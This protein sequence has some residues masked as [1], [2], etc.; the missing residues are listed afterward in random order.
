MARM[1]LWMKQGWRPGLVVIDS[2]ESAGLP[3]DSNNVRPW[4]QQHV[5][6]FLSMGAG[7]LLLDHVPKRREDRPRGGIGSQHKLARIDGAALFLDG[8]PWTKRDD[9]RVT[10]RVHKDRLGD[11][12]AAVKKAVAVVEVTHAEDGLLLYAINPPDADDDTAQDV[13]LPLLEAIASH[14]PQGVR[15][16]KAVRELLKVRGRLIDVALEDLMKTG[17]VVKAKDGRASIF[18]VTA[19]GEQMLT[20]LDPQ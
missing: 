20:E 6:P 13:T 2:V 16:Y 5:D 3:T 4:F 18:V 11:L 12:D 14:G 1:A 17:L 19:A 15:T 9:G 7:V 8:K 10:L